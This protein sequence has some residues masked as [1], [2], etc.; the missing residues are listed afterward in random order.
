M[1]GTFRTLLMHRA[2]KYKAAFAQKLF[3]H[4]GVETVLNWDPKRVITVP[5]GISRA[6][7][8]REDTG[9]P[10]LAANLCASSAAEVY[11]RFW[12]CRSSSCTSDY[13]AQLWK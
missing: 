11:S 2:R 3:V 4:E 6:G 12:P 5:Y 1:P 8:K 7:W 9:E 13:I 10:P